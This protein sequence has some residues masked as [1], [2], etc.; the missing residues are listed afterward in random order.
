MFKINRSLIYYFSMGKR[1]LLIDL[2]VSRT[3]AKNKGSHDF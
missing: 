3:N 1:R 2:K